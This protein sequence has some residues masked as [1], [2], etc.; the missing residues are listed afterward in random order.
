MAEKKAADPIR[1]VGLC[2]RPDS[3]AAGEVARRIDK[4]LAERGLEVLLDAEAGRWLHREGFARSFVAARAD[5]LVVLGGDGTLL[6]VAQET[7][8]RAVPIL[9][10]NLGT[11]GF[12]AEVAPDDL[13]AALEQVLAGEHRSVRRMRFE[14]RAERDGET[15]LEA[16][17]LNDAV[18]TRGELLR[19]LDIETRTDGSPMATY[20]GDG[21]I[22]ATPTGSTAYSLSA[23][24]PILLPGLDA[25]VIT[26]ICPHTLT[27]RP[28][29]LPR[30]SRVEMRVFPREGEAQLNVDGR[31]SCALRAGDRVLVAGSEHAAHFVVSPHRS[32]FD[33]LRAKLRWG[34][35]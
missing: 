29:V 31:A 18:I 9:G 26:P 4:W 2:L 19:M 20:R 23:G 12:L 22:V 33:V 1:S 21:L 11:L 15:L 8:P 27:Q 13:Q 24:G 3:P 30:S 10:V 14:V 6:S 17:A 5:L 34:T 16:L 32:R 35:D 7:G 25:F 28:V